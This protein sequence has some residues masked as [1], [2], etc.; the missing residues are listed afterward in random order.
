MVF[1]PEKKLYFTFAGEMKDLAD[2]NKERPMATA[3]LQDE[4]AKSMIFPFIIYK[5]FSVVYGK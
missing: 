5:I 4:Q 3:S 1:I 2:R